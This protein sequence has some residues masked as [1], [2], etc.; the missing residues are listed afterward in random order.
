MQIIPTLAWPV[1]RVIC[2]DDPDIT[3]YNL[4]SQ[5]T[6]NEEVYR[7]KDNAWDELKEWGDDVENYTVKIEGL[8]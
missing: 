6:R 1:Y 4:R 3:L 8:W 2:R 7:L 5:K